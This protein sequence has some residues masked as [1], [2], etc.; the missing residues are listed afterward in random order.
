VH[1]AFPDAFPDVGVLFSEIYNYAW[2]VG[3]FAAIAVY[4]GLMWGERGRVAGNPHLQ[5]A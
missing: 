1:S 5:G 2:F 4:L 3:V